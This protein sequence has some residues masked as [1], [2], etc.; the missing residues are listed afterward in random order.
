MLLVLRH[1][2]K[3]GPSN[4]KYG[5]SQNRD[6][7]YRFPP[8]TCLKFGRTH[9]AFLHPNISRLWESWVILTASNFFPEKLN[10]LLNHFN[11]SSLQLTLEVSLFKVKSWQTTYT[12]N[13]QKRWVASLVRKRE[14]V[15]RNS[16]PPTTFA[17]KGDPGL[18]ATPLERL[19]GMRVTSTREAKVEVWI[20]EFEEWKLKMTPYHPWDWYIYLH[21]CWWLWVDDYGI[22]GVCW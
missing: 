18:S 3:G 22:Y 20:Q 15:L 4:T 7:R 10:S 16:L 14:K 9:Q 2:C 17:A 12:Q 5:V 1:T 19:A 13:H 21:F 6:D 11:G 8:T